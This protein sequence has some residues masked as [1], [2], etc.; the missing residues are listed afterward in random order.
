M[1]S[2]PLTRL[3]SLKEAVPSTSSAVA[4]VV[5]A[6]VFGSSWSKVTA[7]VGGGGSARNCVAVAVKVTAWPATTGLA[8]ADRVTPVGV[9]RLMSYQSEDSDTGT[10]AVTFAEVE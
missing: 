6:P 10:S 2:T 7:P 9:P 1:S 8:L 5:A 4:K 3:L